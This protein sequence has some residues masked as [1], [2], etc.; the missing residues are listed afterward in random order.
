LILT[1]EIKERV[2]ILTKE[3][4]K[5]LEVRNRNID[6]IAVLDYRGAWALLGKIMCADELVIND[7]IAGCHRRLFCREKVLWPMRE[8]KLLG[9][10]EEICPLVDPSEC[11][12]ILVMVI[13]KQ[14]RLA[15]FIYHIK[16]LIYSLYEQIEQERVVAEVVVEIVAW[17]IVLEPFLCDSHKELIEVF[18]NAVLS[19]KAV[20]D[21][22]VVHLA[23][24]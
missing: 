21:Q 15:V 19:L 3:P 16:D 9:V 24:I 20:A 22:S 12:K 13:A 1:N 10:L 5:L 17:P 8:Q 2:H 18:T 11:A 14:L 6:P 4:R 7:D 23:G